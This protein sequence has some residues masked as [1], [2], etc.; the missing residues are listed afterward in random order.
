MTYTKD[1]LL[2]AALELA[3][4]DREALA[5]EIWLSLTDA[6]QDDIDRAVLEEAERRTAAYEAGHTVG[7][8]VDEVL[9]RLVRKSRS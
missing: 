5:E 4:A 6:E 3:P 9:D 1:Q 8:P 2:A 7:R